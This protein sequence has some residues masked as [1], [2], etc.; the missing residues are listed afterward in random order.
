MIG[1]IGAGISG[2]TLAYSLHKRQI[3]YFVVEASDR[4]GGYL[5]SEKLGKYQLDYGANSLLCDQKIRQWIAEIGLN[6]EILGTNP[7]SKNRYIFK[8]GQYKILPTSPPALI[9]SNFFSWKTKLAIFKE[10]NKKAEHIENETLTSFFKRRFSQEIVDYALNPFV[11]GIYAG[12]PEELLLGK[13]FPLLEEYEKNYGSVLKGFIKNKGNARR[14]SISFK[15][16]MNTLPQKLASII[17]PNLYL[18]TPI[19]KI[20]KVSNVW[21]IN[22]LTCDKLVITTSA[23]S[24]SNLLKDIFPAFAEALVKVNYPPMSVVYSAFKKLQVKHA[25]N[26]FGGLHPQIERQFSAGSIWSSS[27]F[28]DRCP[29]DEVLLTSFVGGTQYATHAQLP[30]ALLLEKLNAELQKNYQIEGSPI[31]QHIF[32][33]EKSIPQYDLNIS[34]VHEKSKDLEK[35]NLWI[36][37]NWQGGVSVADC[38]KK[39]MALG[40]II[41]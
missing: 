25:L 22:D 41:A 29:P 23:F 8:N 38:I 2:L 21:K 36:C 15:G 24:A 1:I 28:S 18:N 34:A 40:E 27:V 14:Q 20:E 31:F 26:G 13:T 11:S 32:R 37:A 16:G 33:W 7:I 17:A 6:D 12:N 39:A 30:D 9:F 4:V 35:E 19:E 10:R 3:P 5:Q